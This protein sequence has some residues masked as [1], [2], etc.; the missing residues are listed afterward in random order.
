MLYYTHTSWTEEWS[1]QKG[2]SRSAEAKAASLSTARAPRVGVRGNYDECLLSGS[3][4]ARQAANGSR[5]CQ[6]FGR[7]RNGITRCGTTSAEIGVESNRFENGDPMAV[8]FALLF[9]YCGILRSSRRPGPGRFTM[10]HW[11]NVISCTIQIIRALLQM[12][13]KPRS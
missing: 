1:A 12:P 7:N 13:R 4:A 6:D 5:K 2:H 11:H 9:H 8:S 3:A 10:P